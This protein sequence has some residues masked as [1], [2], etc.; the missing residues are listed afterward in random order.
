MATGLR[1]GPIGSRAKHLCV[2]MQG[3]F[4]GSSPWAMPWFERVLPNVC[5]LV[6]F[7]PTDTIFTRFI[8][9]DDPAAAGGSWRRYYKRW[10]HMTLD[11]LDAKDVDLVPQLARFVPPSRVVDKRVYSPWHSQELHGLLTSAAADTLVISGGETDVC[12]LSSVLGAIDVGYRVI[13]VTDAVCSSS[14][15]AHDAMQLFFG[16]R[17]SQQVETAETIEIMENWK[18][19]E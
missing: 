10:S 12:V 11:Q 7:S 13:I 17:L 5:R 16:Q 4:T 3:I 1:F 15:E 19:G 6:A 9:A 14:D 2:D 8:P 18:P